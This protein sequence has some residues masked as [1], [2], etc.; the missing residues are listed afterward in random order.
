MMQPD[1]VFPWFFGFV[2]FV[3]IAVLVGYIWIAI[4][5]VS[6]VE[7]RGLQNVLHSIWCGQQGC[8]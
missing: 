5:A 1:K 7:Q 4:W 2:C 3:I 8:K 6:S